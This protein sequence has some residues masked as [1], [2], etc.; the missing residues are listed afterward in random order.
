[1]SSFTCSQSR[2]DFN[3]A[4][5]REE[6]ACAYYAF[7]KLKMDDQTYT[8]LSARAPDNDSY[9]IYP[10]GLLFEEV[11]PENLIEVSFD[12]EI[13]NGAEQSY[14]KTGY[15]IH[16]SIYRQRPDINAIFHLHTIAGVAVAAMQ[17]GLLP[18]SQFAYHFYNRIAYHAYDSLTLDLNQQG[19]RLAQDLGTHKAMILHNHGTLTCGKTIH[20]AFF[21]ASFLEKACQVQVAALAAGRDHLVIPDPNLCEQAYHD[22]TDFEEDIGKRDFEALKRTLPFPW[23]HSARGSSRR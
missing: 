14:N 20:E 19:S 17:F 13:L 21:Y 2:I 6:L 3:E 1:M 16:G 22:L 18:I 4:H 10:L 11:T 8:H 7:A 12:G 23:R 15:V 9:Y 5:I